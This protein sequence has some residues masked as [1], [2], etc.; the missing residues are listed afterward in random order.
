MKAANLHYFRSFNNLAVVEHRG[1]VQGVVSTTSNDIRP[2]WV[3]KVPKPV[4]IIGI[5]L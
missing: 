2:F 5:I 4:D 3:G 1:A